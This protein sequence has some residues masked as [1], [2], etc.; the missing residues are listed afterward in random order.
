MKKSIFFYFWNLNILLYF[1]IKFF[2]FRRLIKFKNNY[3]YLVL[4][5]KLFFFIG[6]FEFEVLCINLCFDY[7]L[8]ELYIFL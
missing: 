8:F 1:Y 4:L 5:S 3:N 6:V 7:E 2:C